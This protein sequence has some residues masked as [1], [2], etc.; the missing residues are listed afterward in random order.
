LLCG[1]AFEEAPWKGLLLALGIAFAVTGSIKLVR[2]TIRRR[3][4]TRET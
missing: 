3:K 4:Q 2:W 1:R